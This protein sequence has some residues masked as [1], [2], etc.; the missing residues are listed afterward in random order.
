[1]YFRNQKKSS[2]DVY[3]SDPIDTDKDGNQLTLLDVVSC[4]DTISDDVDLKIKSEKL[5]QYI[6][7]ALDNRERSI[8]QMRYGIDGQKPK[9]QRE[10]AKLMGISRSYVSRIEK[11]AL[12]DL[13]VMFEKE[14]NQKRPGKP[15]FQNQ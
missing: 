12:Q 1:M 15:I 2:Q 5:H 14:E 10:V 7:E 6:K 8:I 9:T 13:K 3:I 4:E 11:K